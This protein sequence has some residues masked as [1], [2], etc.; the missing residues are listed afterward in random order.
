M[1]VG[2][3]AKALQC[4]HQRE[5]PCRQ[6]QERYRHRCEALVLGAGST[7]TK[8][9]LGGHKGDAGFGGVGTD[10]LEDIV[11]TLV[12]DAG[13]VL[14]DR[15]ERRIV[16]GGFG[17]VVEADQADV[18]GNGLSLFAESPEQAM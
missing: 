12:A 13:E 7:S 10:L 14:A 1:L 8:D 15:G 17:H 16:G 18:L 6:S 4:W 3:R 9:E 11:H 2:A 5:L